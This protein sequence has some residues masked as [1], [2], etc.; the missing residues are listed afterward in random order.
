MSDQFRPEDEGGLH[1]PPGLG[2]WRTAWWWFDFLILVKLARLRFIA[3][4][5]AIGAVILYWDTLI[6]YYEKWT[7]PP[8]AEAKTEEYICPMHPNIVRDHPDKCPLCGMPLSLKKVE[9]ADADPV[10]PGVANRVSFSPYRVALAGLRTWEVRYQPLARQIRAVGTVEF[11]ERRLQRI[12][13]KISGK[14]RIDKLFVNTTGQTVRK[15][16]PLA[17]LYSPDLVATVQNL[18]DARRIQNADLERSA[19]DRLRLWGL[20]DTQI[21]QIVTTGQPVMHVTIPAPIGGHVLKKYQAEGE[22]VEEGARLY[23]VAD[24]STVWIE[25]QVFEDEISFLVAGLPAKATTKA[26]PNEEF[27]GKLSLVYPH[28]DASTRTLKVRFDVPN[29]DHELLPGMYVNVQLDVAAAKIDPTVMDVGDS[30]QLAAAMVLQSPR[31]GTAGFAPVLVG[32][33]VMIGAR[34]SALRQGAVLAVPET[35]VIDTGAE[36]FVY[37]EAKPGVYDGVLVKLGSRCGDFYPVLAGLRPGDKVVTAGSFLVDAETRLGGGANW[38][39]LGATGSSSDRATKSPVSAEKKDDPKIRVNLMKLSPADRELAIAQKLCVVQKE[40]RLGSMGV[41]VK[42]MLEG[43]P[44]FLCCSGCVDE[45]KEQAP[46]IL[47]E[48][49]RRKKK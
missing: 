48:L 37:R 45:A 16:E 4:L 49:E 32:G 11:D 35:A 1:A 10:P 43:Q 31:S 13:A 12:T 24:L 5:V 23:D 19:R 9:K 25:A 28:L 39:F 18:L 8:I 38:T 21:D 2:F 7:R 44:V 14:S 29:P 46:R 36:T 26:Y 15:G 47:K 22:Y 17:Q 30:A 41:P 3:V 40:N 34:Q 6:A 27:V 42:V 33:S 20:P